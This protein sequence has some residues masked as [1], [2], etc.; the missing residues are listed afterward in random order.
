MVAFKAA[1]AFNNGNLPLS[2][3]LVMGTATAGWMAGMALTVLV[4][5]GAVAAIV[6]GV[7]VGT[8]AAAG[9]VAVAEGTVPATAARTSDEGA[10][11]VAVGAAEAGTLA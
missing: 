4:S 3:K 8:G 11:T 1:V 5:I 6:V 9:R 2:G 7:V 10:G